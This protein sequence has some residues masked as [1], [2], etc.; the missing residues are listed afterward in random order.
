[1]KKELPRRRVVCSEDRE[2]VWGLDWFELLENHNYCRLVQW[3]IPI[4]LTA[5][6]KLAT[7]S[8]Y[9][10]VHILQ[11]FN[12]KFYNLEELKS[13]PLSNQEPQPLRGS[14]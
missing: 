14:F 6:A 3:C 10:P 4:S 2:R 5:A 1:M 7:T 8:L 9:N 13:S 12:L 11:S